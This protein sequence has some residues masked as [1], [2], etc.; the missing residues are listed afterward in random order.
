M[1][2]CA[3]AC[4]SAQP[5]DAPPATGMQSM[6]AASGRGRAA[7]SGGAG[8][9]AG[10]AGERALD[11]GV[12]GGRSNAGR[13][14]AGTT[15]AGSGGAVDAQD[16][17]PDDPDDSDAAVSCEGEIVADR[18]RCLQDDAFCYPL[19]DG[20]YCTGPNA[21]QC[22]P[23]TAPIAKTAPCPERTHCFELS[24]SLRCA[25]RLYTIEEC[26]AAGGVALSDPGDGSL[27][28][29]NDALA[30]GSIDGS[31]WDEGGLCCPAPKQC[32]A[33]AGDTC[34]PDEYCAY[35]PGQYC[36]QADAQ[37]TCQKRPTSC[38]GPSAT[39]CGCDQKTYSSACAANAAGIGVY[40]DGSC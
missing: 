22:P 23:N 35:Q 21:P 11:G 24:E 14:A 17:G 10:A 26:A 36:G 19:G 33:R 7:G 2:L 29:P 37:A 25:R 39:V 4:T 16:A 40:D 9:S 30:L 20:R 31:G 28:C 38:S 6:A 5:E 18:G 34:K 13:G 12:A 8:Q 15:A 1:A 32:G 27:V 3:F